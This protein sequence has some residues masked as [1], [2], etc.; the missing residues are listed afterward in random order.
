MIRILSITILQHESVPDDAVEGTG[1]DRHEYTG[2]R[3]GKSDTLQIT[4]DSCGRE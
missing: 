4:T 3:A 2:K 1:R